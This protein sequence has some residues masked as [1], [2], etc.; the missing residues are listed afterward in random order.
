MAARVTLPRIG[1]ATV[2]GA[3]LALGALGALAD[4]PQPGPPKEGFA[5]DPPPR[6]S[7]K[8]W[9]FEVTVT[10]GVPA[11]TAARAVELKQ[12][13]ETPRVMGRFAVELWVGSELIDRA[14]F[15]VPLMGAGPPFKSPSHPWPHPGFDATNTRHEVRL[16]D[17]PRTVYVA[18]VDRMTGKTTRYDWPPEQDGKLAAWKPAEL[19]G[20][21]AWPPPGKEKDA[22]ARDAKPGG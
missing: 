12:P 14:R 11:L 15:D 4:A 6:A 22:G 5:P 21:D 9:M 13:A 2:L 8:Q 17:S 10:K 1:L 3:A 16:A 18:L 7:T 20:P 19:S